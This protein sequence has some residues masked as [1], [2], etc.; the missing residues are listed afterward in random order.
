MEHNIL[1][2]TTQRECMEPLLA[3]MGTI[4]QHSPSIHTPEELMREMNRRPVDLVILDSRGSHE[5]M[6][7][8]ESLKH[9]YPLVQVVALVPYGDIGLID[10][11]LIAGADD[12][13]AQP[14]SLERLKTTLRNAFRIRNLMLRGP[15][16]GQALLSYV[17]ARPAFGLP[18]FF[19][20][21]GHL[22]TLRE[23][24]NIAI[25]HAISTCAGCITK[26]ARA[27]GIG[28]STLYRKMQE[29]ITSSVQPY[30]AR[31][32]NYAIAV[33]EKI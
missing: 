33:S 9:H 19:E 20:K 22:R 16:D 1:L 13:I 23:I 28:R 11:V 25:E 27:L 12:Y 14:I 32:P 10:R 31:I 24:E 21:P 5:G 6:A 4:L 8:I 3:V 29:K 7:L 30:Q 2:I 17:G 15:S 18:V 26:A